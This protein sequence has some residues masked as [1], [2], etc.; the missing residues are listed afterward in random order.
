M[1]QAVLAN[2]NITWI[3]LTGLVLFVVCFG[4][5]TY[6][7]LKKSNGAVYDRAAGLPLED[8]TLTPSLKGANHEHQG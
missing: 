6:W 8:G 4:V 2:F 1:K 3:P 5:F 7:T